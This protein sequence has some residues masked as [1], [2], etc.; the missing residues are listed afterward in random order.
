[1][2][3]SSGMTIFLSLLTIAFGKFCNGCAITYR[4][5]IRNEMFKREN[6]YSSFCSPQLPA[7]CGPDKQ[8]ESFALNSTECNFFPK[9]YMNSP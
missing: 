8:W 5:I 3:I 9:T 4:I 1:M 2:S 6:I 7:I